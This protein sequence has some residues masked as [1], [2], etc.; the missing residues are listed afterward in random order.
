MTGSAC[1]AQR[2]VLFALEQQVGFTEHAV[3]GTH[4][5]REPVTAGPFVRLPDDVEY[6]HAAGLIARKRT[7]T[8]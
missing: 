3:I 7:G 1:C 4:G 5:L 8:A 2:A 6:F